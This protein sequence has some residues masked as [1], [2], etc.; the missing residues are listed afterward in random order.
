LVADLA[1][2]LHA[3]ILPLAAVLNSVRPVGGDRAIAGKLAW[4]FA[5]ARTVSGSGPVG[6]AWPI[7]HSRSI[8]RSGPLAGAGP[9]TNTSCTGPFGGQCSGS[10]TTTSQEFGGSTTGRAAR[11]GACEIA[12]TPSR[13]GRQRARSSRTTRRSDIQ[14]VLQ[15]TG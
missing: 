4:S 9:I 11:D 13:T 7:S 8:S 5:D 12:A 10:G 14:E 1:A 15:L 6:D 2:P 3:I